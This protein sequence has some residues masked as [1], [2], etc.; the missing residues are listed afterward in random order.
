M[1]DADDP[2]LSLAGITLAVLALPVLAA[3]RSTLALPVRVVAF[4]PAIVVYEAF[5][6]PLV[7]GSVLIVLAIG[8]PMFVIAGALRAAGVR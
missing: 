6:V 1:L 5:A 3:W 8:A 2:H 4:V 7:A